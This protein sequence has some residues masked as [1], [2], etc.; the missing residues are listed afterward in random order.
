M[1]ITCTKPTVELRD[2]ARPYQTYRLE[3]LKVVSQIWS[4]GHVISEWTGP[5]VVSTPRATPR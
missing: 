2:E 4:P 3:R 1:E 5:M